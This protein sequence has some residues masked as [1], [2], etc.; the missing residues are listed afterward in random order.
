MAQPSAPATPATTN[1]SRSDQT[2]VNC[3]GGIGPTCGFV[4]GTDAEIALAFSIATTT[5]A[6]MVAISGAVAFGN[7][8]S[9]RMVNLLERNSDKKSDPVTIRRCSSRAPQSSP[10]ASRAQKDRKSVV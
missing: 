10:P 5:T 3:S 9:E 4:W 8:N 1:T 6:K 2:T 7:R